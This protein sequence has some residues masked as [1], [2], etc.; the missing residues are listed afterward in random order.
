MAVP[1]PISRVGCVVGIFT[2]F[3]EHTHG[4]SGAP[5]SQ[6]A[7]TCTKNKGSQCEERAAVSV[8]RVAPCQLETTQFVLHVTVKFIS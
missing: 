2:G 4:F 7:Q 1:P 5:P 8:C 6:Q 3:H